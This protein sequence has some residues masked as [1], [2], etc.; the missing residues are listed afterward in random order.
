[1]VPSPK[2]KVSYTGRIKSTLKEHPIM[3]KNHVDFV[4]TS[5]HNQ[6]GIHNIE[7]PEQDLTIP[8]LHNVIIT[9]TLTL[10][11]ILATALINSGALEDFVDTNFIIA[12]NMATN[13]TSPKPNVSLANGTRQDA[14]ATLRDDRKVMTT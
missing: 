6:P 9:H 5:I 11:G 14:S 4:S 3:V 13:T 1:M 10:N 12:Y 2:R 7:S 8:D